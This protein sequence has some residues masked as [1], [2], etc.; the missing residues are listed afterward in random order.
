MLAPLSGI[1]A[2]RSVVFPSILGSFSLPGAPLEPPGPKVGPRVDFG[3]ISKRPG[4]G[5]LGAL[6]G[7]WGSPGPPR[8]DRG[9]HF[10]AR[11]GAESVK[12][13]GPGAQ[14][15]PEANFGL[16]REGPGPLF[17]DE[18]IGPV[19]VLARGRSRKIGT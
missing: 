1:L 8:G 12:K 7:P 19:H 6:W 16:K 14:Y 3:M 11:S 17:C 13:S 4:G 18:N 10:G 9:R 15:A 5:A 2:T